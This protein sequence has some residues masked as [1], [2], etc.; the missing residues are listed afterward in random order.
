M[1]NIEYHKGSFCVYNSMFCQEGYCPGCDIF[2]QHETDGRH[3]ECLLCGCERDA[4]NLV[5]MNSVGKI[6][7][8]G[9]IEAEQKLYADVEIS[10]ID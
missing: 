4:S 9:L 6:K 1:E 5:T 10:P 8:N 3:E 2:I 7:M